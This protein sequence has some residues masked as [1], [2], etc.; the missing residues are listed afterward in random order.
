MDAAALHFRPRPRALNRLGVAMACALAMLFTGASPALAGGPRWVAGS[1]YFSASAT[2]Q[3]VTW[4]GGQ[5]SYYV[6]GQA[7]SATVSNGY[8][9]TLV[10]NAAAV[11]NAVP[12]AGVQIAYKGSLAEDVKGSSFG[13]TNGVLTEPAD[14]APSATSK[15]LG[16]VYDADGSVLTALYGSGASD[17]T[18]CPQ[19][20]VYAQVDNITTDGHIAHALIIINGLCAT[21]AGMVSVLQYQLVRA[22]GRV[23]GLDWSQA[24]EEQFATSSPTADDLAGW[25]MMHPVER[26]CSENAQT[27]LPAGTTLRTD[28]IAA[29]NRLYP[30]TADNLASFTGKKLTAAN[31]LTVRGTVSFRNGQGMQG[32][33]VVL[34]PLH[35]LT[36]LPDLRYTST[37][38]TGVYFA[39]NAGSLIAAAPAATQYLP[40]SWGSAD[41]TL[42]GYYEISGVPLP[43]GETSANYELTLEP[44]DALYTQKESVGAYVTGQVTPSGTMPTVQLGALAAGSDLTQNI[45][46]SDSAGETF[47]GND[48]SLD[49][50]AAVPPAGE[51]TSRLVGYGHASWF[52][53]TPKAN[54][55]YTVEVETLDNDG[56]PTT[57]K[58]MP[59]IGVWNASDDLAGAPDLSTAQPFNAGALGVTR[60]IVDT[61]APT[62]PLRMAIAD[63]RGDGRP[64]FLYRGRILYADSVQPARL[65]SGG[66]PIVIEGTGFRL[67]SIVK[68]NGQAAQVTSVSPT[69]ITAMAPASNGVTGTVTVEV[70]DPQ[71]LGVAVI[72]D[73]LA[74]TAQSGDTLTLIAAPSGA[75][76]MHVPQPLTVRAMNYDDEWPAP[77]VSVTFTVTEG[78]ATLGCGQTSCTVVSNA[79]GMAV[80]SVTATSSALTQITAS[81]TSGASVLS[82]FTGAAPPTVS[83][84]TP[85]LYLAIGGTAQWTPQ[86]LVL[87][88]G[89][90]LA[91]AAVS[92]SAS[93][94]DI[95]LTSSASTASAAGVATQT[96]QAGPF[97]AGEAETVS[98]CSGASC[99]A[100]TLYAVHVE[101]AVLDPASGT[102]QQ[103]APGAA[104]S[105]VTLEV[106][107]AVGH[108]MAGATVTFYETL[109]AWTAPCPTQGGCPPAPVLGQ[110]TVQAV[111][112]A[113]GTVSLTPMALG[114]QP[115]RLLVLAVTGPNATYSFELDSPPPTQ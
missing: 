72:A 57:A 69:E 59:L 77:G 85:S 29:L 79:D 26:L 100:F 111:S 48:G 99:A 43:A 11:W 91:G 8:A 38:V 44:I 83:A 63:A 88:A 16:I 58:A 103:P 6:D 70:D 101:T 113:D 18:V 27:C 106:I 40:G 53:F 109:H 60:L 28:D 42:E 74:Y 2:G 89:T 102:S 81:L 104:F 51:W 41:T 112:A 61:S 31:T 86:A 73:G 34:H 107:D 50:P 1:P 95:T 76:P 78:S 62:S 3:P 25:P 105:P 114:G 37:A 56:Q 65:P 108:P 23:L 68:V 14:I 10:A 84:L 4:A 22:F 5:V 13:Y 24:N 92:W 20:G 96:L 52:A 32:V 46:I 67:D 98:A 21:N 55:E 82:E 30:V 45:V 49:A 87:N 17:P 19:T 33:N 75:I 80:I 12:T 15:P 64:D 93:A 66:G 7:L 47:A 39:G 94:S 90:P 115:G 110:T 35:P 97:I 71:T 36:G 54:R 9:A